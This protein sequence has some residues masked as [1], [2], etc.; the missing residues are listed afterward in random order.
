ML[1]I[2]TCGRGSRPRSRSGTTRN[3]S[4]FIAST[5]GRTRHG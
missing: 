4:H 2:G 5:P 1:R 3:H